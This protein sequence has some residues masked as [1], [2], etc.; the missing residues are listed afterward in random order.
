M[1]TGPFGLNSHSSL[2]YWG[3]SVYYQLGFSMISANLTPKK[4]SFNIKLLNKR[5]SYPEIVTRILK[6]EQF[7]WGGK[8]ILLYNCSIFG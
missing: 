7:S 3:L 8:N 1:Q 2:T 4:E 5:L 6:H